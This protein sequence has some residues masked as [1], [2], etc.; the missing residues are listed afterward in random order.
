MS[1]WQKRIVRYVHWYLGP[2]KFAS[3]RQSEGLSF[4]VKKHQSVLIRKMGDSD[5][6]LQLNKV[7]N[8]K[9]A[10]SAMNGIL[11]YPGETFSF[12]KLVG[13]P[14]QRRG[15]L[16][17]IELSRGEA[18]PGIGGGICQLANLIHWM[19]LHS[20]LTLV[21]RHHHSFDPFPDQG[22]VLPFGSGATVFYNYR[23]YAFKNNSTQV[24]QLR[25]W[26][27]EKCLEGELRC[28][29]ELPFTYTVFE[30]EH[31]FVFQNGKYF[32]K[33]EIWRSK[34]EKRHQGRVIETELVHRNFAEVKYVPE[35]FTESPIA[36]K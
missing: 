33:N 2:E 12:C 5:I 19:V 4:R 10:V 32:R 24:F 7:E 11:I 18:R 31:A 28:Q 6:Q 26:F 34:C 16:K 14:T 29:H 30:K 23:D 21:E 8:L 22:R 35:V 9:I 15:F 13:R 17:G 25:F 36:K 20:P 1:V 3:K 27:T